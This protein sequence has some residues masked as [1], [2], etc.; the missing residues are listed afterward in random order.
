MY[1][2]FAGRIPFKLCAAIACSA[3]IYKNFAD[4]NLRPLQAGGINVSRKYYPA[5]AEYPDLTKNRNIMARNLTK[6]MY[7]KLRDRFTYNGFTIDDAIQTGVD[8]VG[9]FSFTGIVAGDEQSYQVIYL[10]S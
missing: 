1:R 6:Q 10:T 9:K 5:S 2:N 3:V 7:A 4:V 8:N